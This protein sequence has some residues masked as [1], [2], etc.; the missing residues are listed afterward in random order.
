MVNGLSPAG[1]I[2]TFYSYKGGTGRSMAAANIACL[3]A[4]KLADAAQRVLIMDW[5][6]EAP[7]LHRFFATQME[8]EENEYRPGIIEYFRALRGKLEG[9]EGLSG[10]LAAP[11]GWK[12]LDELLPFDDYLVKD[13]VTG[14]DL[15]KAGRLGPNYAEQVMAFDW[16][17]FYRRYGRV[18]ETF[19]RL[20]AAKF[21]YCLIDSRT[22][23]T[24]VSGI[25]TML[26]PEKLVA[27]FVPNY[28]N[29][30]GALDFVTRVTDHRRASVDFRPPAIYPLPSRIESAE[31]E[32]RVEWRDKYR[33]GFERKFCQVYELDQ[34]P[35]SAYFDEVELPYQPYYAYGE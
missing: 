30:D 13:V 2:I 23:F 34:C 9:D 4:G 22:G 7:G 32:L 24:D 14:V 20:L 29:L 25:C 31:Q 18:I 27:V 17:E 26:L 8:R 19:R 11:G 5:D 16:L 21:A 15:V 6:L 35:L 28:Q 10:R 1:R 12:V 33:R 3:L